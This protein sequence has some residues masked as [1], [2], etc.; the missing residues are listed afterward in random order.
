MSTKGYQLYTKHT[1]AELSEMARAIKADP[2]NRNPEHAAGRSIFLYDK[3]ARRK[4]D[5]LSWAVSMHLG[6][7][8]EAA[9]AAAK[10][11]PL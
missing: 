6:D 10:S 3:K 9:R 1:M 4:L 7:K 11:G 5:D 2:A 8:A